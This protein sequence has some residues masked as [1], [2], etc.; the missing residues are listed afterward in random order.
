MKRLDILILAAGLG[1]RMKSE[2]VKVLHRAGGRPLLDYVLDLA[3]Q[4]SDTTPIV[5]VGHQR[6]E[7]RAVCGDDLAYCV[8]EEQLGTGH[9]VLQGEPTLRQRGIE[10]AHVLV[11]SG[12]VPLIRA[13]TLRTLIDEH[14]SSGNAVTLLSMKPDE[15][16]SY[17]RILR[18]REGTV[19]RIVEAKDATSDQLAIDE[20][21]AGVYLFDEGFLYDSLHSVGTDNAQGEYYLTDVVGMATS[22]GRRAGA[23]IVEDPIEV[24]GVNSRSDLA[25]V[26]NEIRKR[27]IDRL[28]VDGVTFRNPETTVIDSH[29]EIGPDTIIYNGV[30]IEGETRVGKDCVIESGV[31]LRDCIVGDQVHLKSGT[32]AE[33]ARIDSGAIVGPYAHLR[34]ETVLGAGVKIGNFVETK[35]ATFGRGAKASHLSYIGDAEVGEDVNIG[36]GTITCNYDGVDKHKTTLEDGVF[37]GSDTQLVAPVRVGAGAYVGAGSTITRDVPPGALALSRT[38]QKVHEGWATRKREERSKRGRDPK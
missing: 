15:P 26:E 10:G 24:L 35:K 1:T 6:E 34:A 18:D 11:L 5:V 21:N 33:G 19:Q 27:S 8:Q 17:G 13:E 2:T 4:V 38:P 37:I 14:S 31:V 16:G 25:A 7:V 20:V 23:I 22:K 3:R 29:V 32:V 12:D 28:M 30:C 9:A 36:A